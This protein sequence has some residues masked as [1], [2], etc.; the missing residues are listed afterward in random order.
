MHAG[1]REAL[2]LINSANPTISEIRSEIEAYEESES[3]LTPRGKL[4]YATLVMLN[5]G[6]G[7][8]KVRRLTDDVIR[9]SPDSWLS[10]YANLMRISALN[11]TS[12]EMKVAELEQAIK[13]I[14]F[15][16]LLQSSDPLVSAYK[17]RGLS[18]ETGKDSL[19]LQ[20]AYAYRDVAKFDKAREVSEGIQNQN[21]REHCLKQIDYFER[22]EN[23]M[24]ATSEMPAIDDSP[25]AKSFSSEHDLPNEKREPLKQTAEEPTKAVSSEP[26]KE[27]A[28]QSSQWWLWLIGAIVVFGGIG[29]I[30]RRQN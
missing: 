16:R 9:T 17:A 5:P 24:N 28:E 14:N 1:E 12:T 8:Q 11:S 30:A 15:S 7:S 18:E 27:P 10:D 25:K 22:K 20:L 4:I 23:P 6:S 26:V 19:I 21:L 3:S 29:L 13:K 2:S